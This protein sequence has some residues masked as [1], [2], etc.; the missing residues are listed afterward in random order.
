[1][2][3][4][5]I[6]IFASGSGT[7]AENIVRYFS[8]NPKVNVKLI[9]SNRSDAF[10][11][12]RAKNLNVKSFVFSSTDL[13]ETDTVD[14]LLSREKIDIIVLA[15]FLLKVPDRVVTAYR[16]RIINIHPSLLPKYGGKGMYG[17]RVHR[18]VI[19]A[20]DFESGITIHLVDEI[21]DNG[22]TLFQAKCIIEE[23]ETPDSLALKIH[24]L[25][26]EHFP[27]VIDQFI[28]SRYLS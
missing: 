13:R 12:T 16:G 24:E 1:M 22:E 10:V 8:G 23:G 28:N 3:S 19:D 15:G 14:Q 18:A 27:K 6:A 5:N 11:L 25:E 26:K 4:V 17:S 20:C 9:L 7:N 2:E 21:Y